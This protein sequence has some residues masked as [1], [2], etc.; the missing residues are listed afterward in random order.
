MAEVLRNEGTKKRAPTTPV[1]FIQGG[2][3]GSIAPDDA[4]ESNRDTG[5]DQRGS[6]NNQGSDSQRL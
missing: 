6:G 3:G 4:G 2:V 5:G 1:P